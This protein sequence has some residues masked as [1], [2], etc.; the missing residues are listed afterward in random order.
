MDGKQHAMRIK[1]SIRG[2]Y[3]VKAKLVPIARPCNT[4]RMA[5]QATRPRDAVYIMIALAMRKNN[6]KQADE[7]QAMLAGTTGLP[8]RTTSFATNM[9]RIKKLHRKH[10][11]EMHRKTKLPS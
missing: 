5:V 11:P 9:Y 3:L 10:I 8:S 7:T 6:A 4:L 2:V 1:A